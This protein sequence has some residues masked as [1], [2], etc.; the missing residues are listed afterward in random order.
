[1]IIGMA[2]EGTL[3][4]C[5]GRLPYRVFLPLL[6]LV[7]GVAAMM[8]LGMAGSPVLN[9][10]IR[11]GFLFWLLNYALVHWSILRLR[12]QGP[13]RVIP[14]VGLLASLSGFVGIVAT[15]DHPGFLVKWMF[16]IFAF[17]CSLGFL[18]NRFCRETL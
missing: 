17:V 1:M 6:L 3:P 11:A 9:T 8:G 16:G 4:A 14:V 15:D 7:V 13:R 10:L 18:S 12:I 5:L 2:Q